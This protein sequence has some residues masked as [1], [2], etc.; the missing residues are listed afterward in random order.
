MEPTPTCNGDLVTAIHDRTNSD[1]LIGCA[2]QALATSLRKEDKSLQTDR[3]T[4]DQVRECLE[5]SGYLLESRLVRSLTSHGY[6]V[7]PNQ[8]VRDPR[9]GKAREIDLIAEYYHYNRDRQKVAVKTYFVV[10]AINNRFPFVLL[11]ERPYTPS[12]DF[13]NY[14]KLACTPEPNPFIDKFDIYEDKGA[15]WENL[16][17]QY[18]VITTKRG[19][20]ELMAT[21]PDDVYGS[22]LKLAEYVDNEVAVWA[23]RDGSAHDQFWRMFFWQ[24]MLVLSGQLLSAHFQG[25]GTTE[26]KET[27]IGRL[28]FNWHAEETNRTT[29]IE[30]VTEEFFLKHL[31]SIIG[32]DDELEGRLHLLRQTL[33]NRQH[34]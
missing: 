19:D 31:D 33:L 17:S 27:S 34:D 12:A 24:P 1:V 28:E 14:I 11:T 21:H 2:A 13:E 25:D 5:R 18:C 9:T 8:V 10:E 32:K 6:F 4:V 15:D 3:V 30:V 20:K 23:N 22:L 16:F 7:E 26:L 29:V